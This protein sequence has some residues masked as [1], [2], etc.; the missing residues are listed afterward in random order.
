MAVNASYHAATDNVAVEDV[1]KAEDDKGV[2]MSEQDKNR[3]LK[4]SRLFLRK[5]YKMET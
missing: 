1:D 3:R 5:P 2:K 4:R